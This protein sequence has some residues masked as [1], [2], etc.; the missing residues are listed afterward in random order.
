MAACLMEVL[1]QYDTQF[2]VYCVSYCSVTILYVVLNT[3]TNI[4]RFGYLYITKSQIIIYKASL[5]PLYR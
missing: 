3:F 1:S 5:D 4:I 2:A